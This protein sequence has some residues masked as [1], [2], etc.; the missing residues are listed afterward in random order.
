M[1]VKL[2]AN[3]S[4]EQLRIFST[5]KDMI[6]LSHLQFFK[7]GEITVLKYGHLM[8]PGVFSDKAAPNIH[9]TDEGVV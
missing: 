8:L 2:T 5:L 7:M 9:F 3:A 6:I 1:M 4:T